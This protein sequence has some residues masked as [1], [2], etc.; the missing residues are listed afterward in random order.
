MRKVLIAV[1]FTNF[2]Q[3]ILPLHSTVRAECPDVGD[4]W[5]QATTFDEQDLPNEAADVYASILE[6]CPDSQRAAVKLAMRLYEVGRYSEALEFVD[7]SIA[8]NPYN[9]VLAEWGYL[10]KAKVCSELGCDT[11]AR[12]AIDVLKSRFPDSISTT[13]A[14]AVEAALNATNSEDADNALN[15]ELVAGELHELAVNAANRND[16]DRALRLLTQVRELYPET[17]KSLRSLEIKG[18]ILSRMSK[19]RAPEAIDV[20]EEILANLRPENEHSRIRYEAELRLGYLN[21]I[22][23]DLPKAREHFHWLAVNA[24]DPKIREE[25]KL[26]DGFINLVEGRHVEAVESFQSLAE[27][28]KELGDRAE[29]SLQSAGAEFEILQRRRATGSVAPAE[30][31]QLRTTL[32]DVSRLEGV[33]DQQRCRAELMI[34]ES[35]L[36]GDQEAEALQKAELFLEEFDEDIFPQETAT[37]RLTA[38]ISHVNLR[39]YNNALPHLDWIL[40]RYDDSDEVWPGLNTMEQVLF[41]KWRALKR[42]GYEPSL[43]QDVTDR[44]LTVYPNGPFASQVRYV[45]LGELTEEIGE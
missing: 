6:S 33:S 5:A 8:M 23:E 28:A 32:G 11:E 42:G 20:F 19:D 45:E 18:L 9:R 1:L 22:L 40:G 24:E 27:N 3:L 30:W 17:R 16:V 41:Y 15:L 12:T 25:A 37:A 21:V 7:S 43:V 35:Y 29:A 44:I 34:V 2:G 36:W 13:R 10:Y 31:Q 14:E 26:R 38:A 4:L 39:G